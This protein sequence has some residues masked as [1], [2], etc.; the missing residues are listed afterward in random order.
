[1]KG[2]GSWPLEGFAVE[3][4]TLQATEI[5]GLSLWCRKSRGDLAAQESQKVSVESLFDLIVTVERW[6]KIPNSNRVLGSLEN[7]CSK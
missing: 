7:L 4:R 3:P 6:K 1:M 2:R 5:Q